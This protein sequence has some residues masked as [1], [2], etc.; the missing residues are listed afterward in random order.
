MGMDF[1]EYTSENVFDGVRTVGDAEKAAMMVEKIGRLD[2]PGA[3][4]E[5]T[6]TPGMIRH[7]RNQRIIEIAAAGVSAAEIRRDTGV[8]TSQLSY[9]KKSLGIMVKR[10]G[11]HSHM[12]KRARNAEIISGYQAGMTLQQI[13]DEYGITR[14]RVRQILATSGIAPESG[15]A[16]KV[17]A[18]RRAAGLMS[19]DVHKAKVAK[20][21]EA[22]LARMGCTRDQYAEMKA[23]ED[24][25]LAGGGAPSSTPIATFGSRRTI[26]RRMG[27]E[28]KLTLGEWWGLW[29]ESG[30]WNDRGIGRHYLCRLD[31]AKPFEIGNVEIRKGMKGLKRNRRD[32]NEEVGE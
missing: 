14:E 24:G 13:S 30:K 7:E 32:R 19:R 31:T 22:K 20:N 23:E 4:V 1:S 3:G 26:A 15:G 27:H 29:A 5:R 9:I 2:G 25:W 21:F 11:M 28:W 8:T 16:K 18:E 12:V 6:K 17:F 10:S